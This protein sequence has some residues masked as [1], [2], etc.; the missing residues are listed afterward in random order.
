M[1]YETA[2]LLFGVAVVFVLPYAL[3]LRAFKKLSDDVRLNKRC[4]DHEHDR[5]WE[6]KR[7][8]RDLLHYMNL[9]L[10]RVTEHTVIKEKS[11]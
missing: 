8:L 11:K 5:I 2:L 1:T 6:V 7:D 10:Y 9:D 4:I 3:L